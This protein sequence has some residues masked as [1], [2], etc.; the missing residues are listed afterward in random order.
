MSHVQQRSVEASDFR[1][2]CGLFPTGVTVVTRRTADGRPYGM[3]VSSFTSVSLEPPLI[4]ICIDKRAGFLADFHTAMPFAVNVLREDQQNVA[5]RFSQSL[6]ERRFEGL[7]WTEGSS[8]VPLLGGA[9]ASFECRLVQTVE[10]GDHFVL[11]GEVEEIRR[12]S[13]RALVWCESGY[14]CLPGLAG[15]GL[16]GLGLPGSQS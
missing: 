7:D 15:S 10:A 6:E 5:V 14:H 1:G 12:Q 11:I 8:G 3:T 16:P 9:V 4:L 13:G 2:A